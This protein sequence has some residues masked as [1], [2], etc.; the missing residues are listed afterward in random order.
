MWGGV[1]WGAARRGAREGFAIRRAC[2]RHVVR[3][4]GQLA[5]RQHAQRHSR[6]P[7]V[8]GA[9]CAAGGA[10]GCAAGW[11]GGCAWRGGRGRQA[12]GVG[13]AGG[14]TVV[15]AP[16]AHLRRVEGGGARRLE[17]RVVLPHCGRAVAPRVGL[18]AAGRAGRAAATRHLERLE[19][20]VLPAD[21]RHAEVEQL[22]P[23][24]VAHQARVCRADTHLAAAAASAPI[25][26][27]APPR[28][29]GREACRE[30]GQRRAGGRRRAGALRPVPRRQV[31][32]IPGRGPLRSG[33]C[34][35]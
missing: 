6:R 17:E 14:S 23:R 13:R 21:G 30:A 35:R 12:A 7:D 31:C 15:G 27:A 29:Q 32:P 1:G 2:L 26:A 19:R 11:V 20:L 5:P 25:A 4:E 34:A 24:R 9:A 33:R 22:D 10:G 18:R 28:R 16:D 3:L 8:G